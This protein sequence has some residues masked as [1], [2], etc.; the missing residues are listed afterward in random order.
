MRDKRYTTKAAAE[1]LGLGP[2]TVRLWAAQYSEFM[3]GGGNPGAGQS[4]SFSEADL[5]VLQTVKELRKRENLTV[6]QCRDRLREIPPSDLA[7][8][9]IEGTAGATRAAAGVAS[10][11]GVA[12][13][14]GA[15]VQPG[16]LA[17]P[18]V[19]AS[20]DSAAL[21]Q[22][23]LERQDQTAKDVAA[24]KTGAIWLAVGVGV[25]A[26]LVLVVVVLA[27]LVLR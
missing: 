20:V 17:L 22:R 8:P 4:R 23:L 9:Y 21:L 16:A 11:G 10:V 26:L 14:D 18:V 3:S 27:L 15:D 5:A 25:G 24:L 6:D 1:A 7:A 19:A 2:S 12:G 13:A